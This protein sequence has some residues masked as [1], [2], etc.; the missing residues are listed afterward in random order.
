MSE[1]PASPS[2]GQ[3]TFT[4]ELAAVAEAVA[5]AAEELNRLD[6]V[7]GDG[8]LGVTMTQAAGALAAILQ[9]LEGQDLA[10]QLRR[11]G[12]ELARKAPSTSG[13]LVA[14]GFLRA[15]RAAG[16]AGGGSGG[17]TA[18][19]A[20]LLG[21]AQQGIQER[22]KAAPGDRTLLDAL[23]PAVA[24]LEAAGE[25]GTD[26]ATALERAARAAHEGAEATRTMRAKVGR[27]GWLADR[28]AGHVDA[29]AYL[30]ALVLDAA[31]RRALA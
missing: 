3:L 11:C 15:A 14:T 8:D 13:T 1:S 20:R 29:G 17:D 5:G 16:E 10:A 31:A 25:Q 2:P 18:R 22:G 30:V 24:A 27:A 6:A 28:A 9:E 21:A 12:G 26:V 19:L 7:A 4:A 23:A